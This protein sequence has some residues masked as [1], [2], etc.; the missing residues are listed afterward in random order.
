MKVILGIAFLISIFHLLNLPEKLSKLGEVSQKICQ[1]ML[2]ADSVES[3]TLTSL[4]CGEKV[5]DNE[6][7][8][9]LRHT[10][11]IH[12]FVVSGGH[13]IVLCEVF[14]FF[15]LHFMV[16]LLLLGLFSLATG[17]QAPCLRALFQLVLGRI[18]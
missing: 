11:L 17:F 13:L 15:R 18:L 8:K 10:G 2:A 6:K 4:V 12:I 14:A 5:T 9:W 1:E 16:Q 7:R 3:A